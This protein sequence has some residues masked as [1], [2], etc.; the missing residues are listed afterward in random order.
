MGILVGVR[1]QPSLYEYPG[2]MPDRTLAH[3]VLLLSSSIFHLDF[4]GLA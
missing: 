2:C 3:F 1:L 4:L